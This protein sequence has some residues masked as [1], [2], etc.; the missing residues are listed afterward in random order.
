MRREDVLALISQERDRQIAKHGPQD[1]NSD[2]DWLG[3][4]TEELGEAAR[5]VVD[6]R[7]GRPN[8]T[9]ISELT[10]VAAVAVSWLEKRT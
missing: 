2:M 5:A 6:Q 7:F 8:D 4:L 10:H 1:D 9:L 3:I